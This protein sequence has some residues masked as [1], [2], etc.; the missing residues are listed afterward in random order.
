MNAL[1]LYHDLKNRDIRLEADGEN[2]KVDAPAGMLTDEHRAA[3]LACKPVLLGLLA[4]QEDQQGPE[5]DGRRF[6]ARPSR[7]PG[8]TSLYDPVGDRW[9]DFPTADCYPSIVEMANRD[10]RKGGA[11]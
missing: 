2:L 1:K 4:W 6:D 7:Y 9:H 11:A 3:L 8:Y 10:Q 5:D